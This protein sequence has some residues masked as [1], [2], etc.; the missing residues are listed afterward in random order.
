MKIA[1]GGAGDERYIHAAMIILLL[2]G[3]LQLVL[4]FVGFARI[5][6]KLISKPVLGGFT[7]AS[8]MIIMASQLK[9]A[10]GINVKPS[11]HFFEVVWSVLAHIGLVKFETAVM[12]FGTVSFLLLVQ[13]YNKN[14]GK[15]IPGALI[16][17]GAC[18]TLSFLFDLQ[19]L[20][21]AILGNVPT[22]LPSFQMICMWI[23]N[24]I[25]GDYLTSILFQR[26]RST[27]SILPGI[28]LWRLRLSAT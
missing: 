14:S 21:I 11:D 23:L 10:T 24:V 18:T 8:A 6:N 16:A 12:A 27:T 28:L 17:V 22:G 2:A 15:N 4:G 1:P 7:S 25:Q 13:I 20:G 19:S 5:T 9:M 3:T 26:F